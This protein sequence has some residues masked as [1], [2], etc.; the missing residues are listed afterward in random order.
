MLLYVLNA[1]GYICHKLPLSVLVSYIRKYKNDLE[2]DSMN[3]EGNRDI[4]LSD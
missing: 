4:F 3:P 2:I 1:N